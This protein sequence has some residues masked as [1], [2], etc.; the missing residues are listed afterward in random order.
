M[1][2]SISPTHVSLSSHP[3]DGTICCSAQSRSGVVG[4]S[5]AEH[6]LGF[7][8]RASVTGG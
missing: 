3:P 8:D 1:L 5:G 2:L 6:H 4:E 7:K